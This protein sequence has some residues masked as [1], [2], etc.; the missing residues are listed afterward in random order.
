MKSKIFNYEVLVSV[1]GS[2]QKIP[3]GKAEKK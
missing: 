2:V 1:R 3:E